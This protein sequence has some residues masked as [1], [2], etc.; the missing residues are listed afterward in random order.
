[1]INEAANIL[2][3]GIAATAVDID[4]VLVHGY[5]FARWRG[6]LMHYA[7]QIGVDRLLAMLRM[8]AAEDPLVW[9]PSPVIMDCAE[10]KSVWLIG[11]LRNN[12][13]CQLLSVYFSFWLFSY[14]TY[15]CAL[16]DIWQ[17][18]YYIGRLVNR[19]T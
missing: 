4:L 14:Q 6:G 19:E 1:M 16:I 12:V 7:D 5:G 8:F 17:S 10:A 11:G 13:C 3:D 15:L 9:Q 18:L 2:Y